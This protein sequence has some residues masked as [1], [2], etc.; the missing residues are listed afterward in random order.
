MLCIAPYG[1]TCAVSTACFWP[2][3]AFSE[4]QLWVVDSTG[5]DRQKSANNRHSCPYKFGSRHERGSG[6]FVVGIY[7]AVVSGALLRRSPLCPGKSVT[8][9]QGRRSGHFQLGVI[10]VHRA[11]LH[12]GFL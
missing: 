11:D 5:G 10:Q 1:I 8:L 3:A 6:F 12:G 7:G 4:R 9:A 2:L